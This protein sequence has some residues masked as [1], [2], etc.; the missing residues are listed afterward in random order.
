MFAGKEE[1]EVAKKVTRKCNACGNEIKVDYKNIKDIIFYKNLYYH[2]D[3]FIKFATNKSKS[4]RGKPKE[5][6]E[7]LDN[8]S[9]IEIQTKERLE[10]DTPKDRLNE[11]LIKEYDIVYVP[12]QFWVTVEKLNTGSIAWAQNDSINGG[13]PYLKEMY[14]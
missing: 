12:E 8:I 5:W 13:L 11:Y 6:Q 9:T 10:H 2:K 1:Y 3:C 14:W 4:K 7:A